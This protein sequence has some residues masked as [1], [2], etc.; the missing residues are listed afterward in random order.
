VAGFWSDTGPGFYDFW[1]LFDG[2]CTGSSDCAI[3]TDADAMTSP[4]LFAFDHQGTIS[5]AF[6]NGTD[7]NTA[8]DSPASSIL[9]ESLVQLAVLGRRT[10][11]GRRRRRRRP[12]R[13]GDLPRVSGRQVA[14]LAQ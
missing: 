8:S 2:F 11:H 3:A 14:A 9:V 6:P 13:P 7:W 5:V 4:M 1:P 12:P 10:V